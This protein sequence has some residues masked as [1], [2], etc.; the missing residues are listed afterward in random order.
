MFLMAYI[1]SNCQSNSQLLYERD[2]ELKIILSQEDFRGDKDTVSKPEKVYNKT[3]QKVKLPD[4]PGDVN[5]NKISS[6][7]EN[8]EQKENRNSNQD[9]NQQKVLK[10]PDKPG[11]VIEDKPPSQKEATGRL[12]EVNQ[13]QTD[14]RMNATHINGILMEPINTNYTR[15]IYFTVKT[16]HKFYTERLFP[17]M[18]T[19]LQLMDKN[20]V[21]CC[22]SASGRDSIELLV[23][24]RAIPLLVAV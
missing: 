14:P 24:V 19:W 22:Y 20:K 12:D 17:L 15:N 7:K 5:K 1:Y 16:T 13:N 9:T 3:E 10:L 18:L 11:N 6:Q 2:Q 8:D 21:S 23:H 4:R